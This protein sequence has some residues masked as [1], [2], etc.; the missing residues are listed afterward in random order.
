MSSRLRLDCTKQMG[1]EAASGCGAMKSAAVDAGA[2]RSAPLKRQTTIHAAG[3]I[4]WR[5]VCQAAVS[6]VETAEMV[7]G[8]TRRA[9]A[10]RVLP[11]GAITAAAADG[12]TEGTCE[13]TAPGSSGSD[14]R[15]RNCDIVHFRYPHQADHTYDVTR[16]H[17]HHTRA[18]S[19]L[20]TRTAH[21][22]TLHSRRP[23]QPKRHPP[24][25]PPCRGER[26]ERRKH[27]IRKGDGG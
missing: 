27:A 1:G 7:V 12:G 26:G 20:S 5:L 11:R 18:A 8:G 23:E 17:R 9:R 22:A 16:T 14:G 15:R 4:C 3:N 2:V 6:S 25:E 24:M 13:S 21:A 19:A 10:K